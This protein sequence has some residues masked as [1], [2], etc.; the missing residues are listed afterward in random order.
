MTKLTELS[1]S[2]EVTLRDSDLHAISA[3]MAELLV[4]S[5]VEDGLVKDI[6]VVGT[7]LNI[8]KFTGNIRDRLFAKKLLFFLSE[9]SNTT[10]KQRANILRK[11]ETEKRYR[12][13]VGEKLIY[14]I[15]RCEDHIKAQV[16]ARLFAAFINQSL[17]YSEFLR[18]SSIVDSVYLDDL[19]IFISGIEERVN[20]DNVGMLQNSGLY[21]IENPEI[22]IRDQDDYKMACD[23][24]IVEG[25]EITVY[26]SEIGRQI[27]EI[28]GKS[29][30]TSNTL[31]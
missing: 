31:C 13:K 24:Y 3:N 18:A 12:G 9:L 20:I 16:I 14:I 27:R 19:N 1:K 4:D 6:P 26:I 29:E 10:T 30:T 25:T 11:L 5:F 17:S 2:L 15:D 28:L 23:P 22:S 21:Y 8:G 7:L